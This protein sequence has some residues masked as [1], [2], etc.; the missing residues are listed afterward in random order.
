MALIE[1]LWAPCYSPSVPQNERPFSDE[2]DAEA[3]EKPKRR[4]GDKRERILKAA[5]KVFAD[6]GFYATRVSEIAKEAGVADGTIYLYFENKD[7]V[8][9][10]IFE[11]RIT[12]LLEVLRKKVDEAEG[13]E[14]KLRSIIELQLGLLEDERDLAEVITVNLRQS[15][16]LLKQYATP[17][18]TEYLELIA[19]VISDG[20]D[21]G[22]VR[23]DISPRIAARG[24]FGALDGIAL[25]WALGNSERPDQ[26][27][28]LRRAATQIATVFLDG[29]RNQTETMKA[30][31]AA[32]AR[33]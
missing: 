26:P 11:D 33:D 23:D 9:I 25:T 1:T 5:T 27:A 18:F 21:H 14:A 22:D 7:A 15:S 3:K 13:F 20:Q 19:G 12:A 17:L 29:L 28:R 16:R 32:S 8:L 10:S 4:S 31:G 24:L 6:N 2:N 30:D